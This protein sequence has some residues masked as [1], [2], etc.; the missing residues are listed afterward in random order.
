MQ[1]NEPNQPDTVEKPGES[2]LEQ[3]DVDAIPEVDIT[4]DDL[5]RSGENPEGWLLYGNSYRNQRFTVADAITPD[6]VSDIERE[7]EITEWEA[8]TV[9]E[10]T[11][12]QGAPLVVPGD[13]PIMY[14]VTAPNTLRA[15][16]ARSGEIL[17][18]YT[19]HN[20][21]GYVETRPPAG[22]GPAVYGDAVYMTTLDF[23][24]VALNRYTG[25]EKWYYNGAYEYRGT[26]IS[27]FQG[28]EWKG[29]SDPD[30]TM[31]PELS[32]TRDRGSSSTYP[33]IVHDGVILKGS[34]GGEVGVAG[35]AEGIPTEEKL[36]EM[37]LQPEAETEGEAEPGEI[38]LDGLTAGWQIPEGFASPLVGDGP[39]PTLTLEAGQEYTVVWENVDGAPHNFAVLTEAGEAT[40]S[41]EIISGQGET[42]TVTFTASEQMAT[43]LCEVHPQS[44][45]G[46]VE[47]VAELD[48]E[49]QVGNA[50][51]DNVTE[52]PQAINETQANQTADNATADIADDETAA[53]GM[54][55]TAMNG[56]GGIDEAPIQ[57]T[58]GTE[59][60]VGGEHNTPVWHLRMTPPDEWIGESWKHGGST[61]WQAPAVDIETGRA[62]LPTSNPG[63]WFG[64][65]R[66]GWNPFSAGKIAVD[67]H[68]GDYQ[69]HFQESPHDWW[70]YDS[71]NP[72]VI[73]DAE[74]GGEERTLVSWAGKTAWVFTVDLETGELVTRSEPFTEHH[75]MWT[76]PT[77][78]EEGEE[79]AEWIMPHLIGGTDPQP[80]SYDPTTRTM[81][82]KGTNQPMKLLWEPIEYVLGMDYKGMDIITG[83][84][85]QRE[86]LDFWENPVGNLTGID[87]VTGEIKWQNW[88]DNFLW[89]G[90]LS[91]A[92]GLTFAGI[93][94]GTFRVYDT[95]SGEELGRDEI[96]PGVDGNPISWV[97]PETGKQYVSV[98]AGGSRGGGGLALVTYSLQ[99]DDGGDGQE[100][101]PN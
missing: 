52:T 9:I 5:E 21:A 95:E 42:Q 26:R 19:Y 20:A 79:A 100:T 67:F 65:V 59:D 48:R 74:V 66:P 55:G 24:L 32:W 99:G 93:A 76:L 47:V 62:V 17:W 90:V 15:I 11:G 61:V 92:S 71:P 36:A 89:G 80:A 44:M 31:H 43:Y 45:R 53:N 2:E 56:M 98:A 4:Y 78:K 51:A 77:R 41:S 3:L 50:T 8:D 54:G 85:E 35:W 29:D 88:Y 30:T 33:P 46:D 49:D 37:D 91:T 73:Y 87:P 75:N 57:P 72:A 14:H 84:S 10:P 38:R 68:S 27:D 63:P 101:D 13:P 7:W 28:G 6:N 70:D 60:P 69:W 96:G 22:R 58:R 12:G 39:N 86:Q 83:A 94:D 34:F 40:V 1:E 25:E 82:L 81:V 16:N 97:D 18:R 64:T 23:G